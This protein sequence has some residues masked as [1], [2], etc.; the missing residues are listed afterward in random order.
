VDILQRMEQAALD[1]ER[2][3]QGHQTTLDGVVRL[4]ASD[5]VS[6]FD[7]PDI[8]HRVRQ[9]APALRIEIIASNDLQDL[10]RREA[11]IAI[12]HVRPEQPDLV[13]RKVATRHASLYAAR[14]YLD[15]FGTPQTLSDLEN[16]QWVSM[17]PPKEMIAYMA[18]HGMNLRDSNFGIVSENGLVGW[19]YARRGFG[20]CV[21]SDD[22]AARFDTMVRLPD[23][24]TVDY[25]VW[26]VAHRDLHHSPRMRLLFDLF[27]RSSGTIK[28]GRQNEWRP[29]CSKSLDYAAALIVNI[30]GSTAGM[31]N[32]SL[33]AWLVN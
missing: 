22:I 11:D 7:L 19:E 5:I 16:A 12:R 31:P 8:L 6:A 27:G 14:E 32:A 29:F 25:P 10:L 33:T 2:F 26:L 1:L 4:T 15:R 17:A 20:I 24:F 30:R 3:A 13:A 18:T 9:R 28:N 23:L 21:M